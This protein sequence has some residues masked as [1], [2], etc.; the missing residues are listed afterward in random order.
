VDS[1]VLLSGKP[2]DSQE[3][4]FTAHAM[5]VPLFC[6]ALCYEQVVLR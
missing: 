4:I 2:E 1:F 3:K 5:R 6:T